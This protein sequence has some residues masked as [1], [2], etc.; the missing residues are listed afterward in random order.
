MGQKLLK[1]YDQAKEV[2]G[3]SAQMRLAILTKIPAPKAENIEDS[4]E[5]IRIF[6]N[7]LN[8]IRE[9]YKNK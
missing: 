6:S 3:F 5:N 2:G 7:A 4:S 1:M 8:T 9:E